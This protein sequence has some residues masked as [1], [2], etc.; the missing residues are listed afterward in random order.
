MVWANKLAVNKGKTKYIIFRTSGKKLGTNIHDLV[1][2]ENEVGSPF[3]PDYVTILERYHNNQIFDDK[4]VDKLLGIL[5]D[6]QLTLDLHVNQLLK[7]LSKSLY[8]INM[9]KNN[10]NPSGL[11]SLYFAL[12]H[13]HLSYCPIVVPEYTSN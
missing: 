7:K 8:R 4:K 2:N 11:R 5:L 6:E 1:F 3:N 9:A 12:I 10:L 13:S